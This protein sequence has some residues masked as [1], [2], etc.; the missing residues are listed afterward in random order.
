MKNYKEKT[1]R[2][3]KQKVWADCWNRAFDFEYSLL[4]TYP[5]IEYLHVI[6]L[7]M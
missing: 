6:K 7:I 2:I 3:P 5:L 1:I 4:T